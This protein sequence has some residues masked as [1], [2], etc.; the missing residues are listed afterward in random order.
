MRISGIKCEKPHGST[1]F[2]CQ[3]S[4]GEDILMNEMACRFVHEP[5]RILVAE[6]D[7]FLTKS[8]RI[9]FIPLT[10]TGNGFR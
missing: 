9:I 4:D 1:K 6:S 10:K 5:R 3:E 7:I 8:V 2:I